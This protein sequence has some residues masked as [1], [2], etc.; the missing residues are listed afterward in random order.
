MFLQF[1]EKTFSKLERAA[2]YTVVPLVKRA[3]LNV[4]ERLAQVGNVM[5]AESE[6]ALP[7]I[8]QR[9]SF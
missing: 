9:F 4:M 3:M 6:V 1:N 5:G 2:I 7:G 8:Y